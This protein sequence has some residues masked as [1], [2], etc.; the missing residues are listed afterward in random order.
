MKP[1]SNTTTY[2]WVNM[3]T[4][5]STIKETGRNRD[6]ELNITQFSSK[7]GLMLQLTQGFGCTELRKDF[8]EPGFIQLSITDAYKLIVELTKWIKSESERRAESLKKTIQEYKYLE[9][10]IIK[11]AVECERFIRDL[12]I[13]DIP[14]MLLKNVE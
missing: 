11:D 3:S 12:E 14:L 2:K 5:I 10:T 1:L 13:L 9:K 6:H 8:D 4:E 7:N